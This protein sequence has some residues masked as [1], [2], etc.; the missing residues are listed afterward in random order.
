MLAL[1]I[2]LSMLEHMLPPIPFMPPS[3]RIGL[4]NVVVMYAVMFI[5]SKEAFALNILKSGFVFLTRGY[6]AAV[7]SLCGGLLSICAMVLLIAIFKQKVSIV[8]LSVGSAIAHNV[9]QFLAISIIMGTWAL[10]YYLPVL[11]VFGTALGVIT[12]LVMKVLLPVLKD[13]LWNK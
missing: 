2:V 9:G 4:A 10:L 6:V 1:M 5:G 7:L 12:G 11:L 13:R 3:M 8:I